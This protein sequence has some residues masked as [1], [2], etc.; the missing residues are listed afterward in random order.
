MEEFRVWIRTQFR[1]SN[2]IALCFLCF[3]I[4]VHSLNN[5]CVPPQF[6]VCKEELR[7]HFSYFSSAKSVRKEVS[8]LLARPGF[9]SCLYSYSCIKVMRMMKNQF[10]LLLGIYFWSTCFCIYTQLTFL[11]HSAFQRIKYLT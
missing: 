11:R 1:D 10:S 2:G 8:Y 9:L 3:Y 4:R 6:I 7:K 5:S